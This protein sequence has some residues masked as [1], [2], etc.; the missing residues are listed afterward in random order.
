M[1]Q[2]PGT[3]RFPHRL[4]VRLSAVIA[5]V[6]L[7][8]LVWLLLVVTPATGESLSGFTRRTLDESTAT[9]REVIGEQ[10][11][12]SSTVLVDLIR[13]TTSA[14]AQ[15][16]EDLPLES[17][18]GDVARIRAAIVQED[19]ER[20]ARQRR[21]VEVLAAEMQRRADADIIARLERLSA[22]RAERE[23]RFVADV[24]R[25]H[26]VLVAVTLTALLL[27][28]GFGM[29]RLVVAPARRLRRAT[30][31]IADG[32]LA[33][34]LPP[35]VPGELGELTRDFGAMMQQLRQSRAELQHLAD[36]L[37]HE[38]QKKTADLE[39]SHRQLAAAE[40]YA[41]LGT[42]AGG[43]A[44][45]FHNVIGGIRGC[46]AELLADE[47]DDERR[48]T[49]AVIERAAD[50]GSAIV[51][52]LQRFAQQPPLE[53]RA[54]T[55]VAECLADALALCE[56]AARRQQVHIE[57]DLE[58]DCRIDA[59]PDGLHQVFVNVLVNALQAMPDGGR[60]RVSLTRTDEHVVARFRDTGPGI[61][62]ELLARVFEPFFTT[63]ADVADP[64]RRGSGLGLSISYGIVNSHGGS[65]TASSPDGGGA[66]FVVRLPVGR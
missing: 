10:T 43:V 45:E 48:E 21:N 54:D 14:R 27:V 56:P 46:A 23:R 7:L 62:G 31:R 1:N 66:E 39:T 59:D 42:L 18:G 37:E 61:P 28:L 20:S 52:R 50:R 32:L 38:V 40:R 29:N 57:R 6:A 11:R 36:N 30:Q 5:L 24:S 34:E 63:R 13:H 9:M 15:A 41:A 12:Q 49:L 8:L 65:I 3:V 22:Q 60:L 53:R 35:A 44:H 17:L 19:A 16:L 64:A 2:S 58:S 55:D 4:A 47:R 25:T 26:L 51:Q 33:T